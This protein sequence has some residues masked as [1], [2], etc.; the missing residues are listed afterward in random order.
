[1]Y[2]NLP[3]A[4]MMSIGAAVRRRDAPQNARDERLS[5]GLGGNWRGDACENGMNDRK[6]GKS[7][8]D[9]T[10]FSCWRIANILKCRAI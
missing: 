4:K 1:M 7:L 2:L 8:E 6:L 9:E 3:W 10:R 5:D